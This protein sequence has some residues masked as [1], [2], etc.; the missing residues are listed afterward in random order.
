MPKGRGGVSIFL[1]D[2]ILQTPPLPFPLKGGEC[3]RNPFKGKGAAAHS[4]ESE[5]EADAQQET[6]EEN[7][8]RGFAQTGVQRPSFPYLLHFQIGKEMK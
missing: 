4:F 5:Q 8:A 2:K 3:L 7:I 1:T 6:I